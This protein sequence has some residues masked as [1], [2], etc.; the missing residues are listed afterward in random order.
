MQAWVY[1]IGISAY[2][3]VK[4]KKISKLIAVLI[5]IIF[6]AYNEVTSPEIEWNPLISSD[7]E[8]LGEYSDEEELLTLNENGKFSFVAKGKIYQGVWSRNDWNVN[9]ISTGDFPYAYLRLIFHSDNYH[10]V[11]GTENKDPDSW[12]Y[13]NALSKHNKPLKQDK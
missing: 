12:F 5:P 6:I 3:K 7:A 4:A 13:S 9:L 2:G 10:L 11:K 8:I 1:S